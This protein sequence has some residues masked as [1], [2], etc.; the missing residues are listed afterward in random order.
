VQPLIR[1]RLADRVRWRGRG[2]ACGSR[3]P[4]IEVEG[5]DDDTLLL[6]DARHRVVALLPMALATLLEDEAGLLRFQLL[7]LGPDALELRLDVSEARPDEAFARA[8]AAL[9]H[10]LA[11]HGLANVRVRRGERPLRAATRSGKLRRVLAHV[12]A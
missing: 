6:R 8:D 2:C 11:H 9:R 10:Y 4:V 7:Q 5:R 1:Y 3:L 12:Q